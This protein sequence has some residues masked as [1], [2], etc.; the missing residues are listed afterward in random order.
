MR[1]RP[2]VIQPTST[3]P[4]D[5]EAQRHVMLQWQ[6][7]NAAGRASSR[8]RPVVRDSWT[9][10]LDAR[11]LPG[12]GEAPVVWDGDALEHA[13]SGNGWVG[14]A[15]RCIAAQRG[16]YAAGGSV[17][18]LFDSSGRMLHAEGEAGAL[19]GLSAINFRPGAL[20]SEAAVGTNGPGT[21]LAL[22]EP[23]H[24]V[25]AEHFCEQWQD[26]HCAAVPV[27]DPL[28]RRLL[29]AIDVSGFRDGAH[30]HTLMLVVALAAT[31]EQMLAA[32]EM[33]RRAHLLTRFA[34]LA[35]RWPGEPLVV[36]DRGGNILAASPAAPAALHPLA[37][38]QQQLREEIA[39]LVDG[40]TGETPL[41][42]ALSCPVAGQ[43]V[44]HPVTYR[45]IVV[46]ACL[47]VRQPVATSSRALPGAG[48]A[49]GVHATRGLVSAP[50]GRRGPDGV[51]APAAPPHRGRAPHRPPTRYALDDLVGESRALRDARRIAVAAAANTLPVLLLGE[52]GTGKEVFAQGIHAASDRSARPFIAVNCAALPSE[53]VESELFGYVGGA[54]SGARRDGGTGKFEAADG[55]TIFLD[56]VGDLPLPAQAAL[57]RVLQ[58]G[59]VTRV[60]ATRGTPVDV[61]V[62]AATNRDIDEA[63]RAG[64]FREDLYYRLSVLGIELPSLRERRGD[65]E[66][67]AR[68][69]LAEA[70]EELGRTGH[71]FAPATLDLLRG[72]QWP[73]NI[74]ELKNLVWR[75][76]ALAT[77]AVITPDALPA[78]MRTGRAAAD[79]PTVSCTCTHRDGDPAAAAE[80]AAAEASHC[81]RERLARVVEQAASMGE[82]AATL[83]VARST[84]YR[85]LQRHGLRPGRIVRR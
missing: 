7:T 23:V 37:P 50:H 33:E 32:R 76:V 4:L 15:L 29:G 36:V 17:V 85:Q 59:E 26:W 70:G 19:E 27:R 74:R 13:R 28:T 46:G 54:F 40:L 63:L 24:V 64:T 6:T 72:W 69:F 68:R 81:E 56:E 1:G 78:A 52:S 75:A 42:A 14:I 44:A 80:D 71:A 11:V 22:G 25:G 82:A 31:I 79:G 66:G 84:L 60:G 41:E 45:G 77:D 61:R 53:L 8:V 49:R 62:I 83:G 55:G 5:R 30:P 73:G 48:S 18:A 34:E 51:P 39:A 43:A 58:E 16:G 20:W 21:A 9:R 47:L 65:I 10:S 38:L 2:T 35:A 57:L 3:L 12:L 67:L